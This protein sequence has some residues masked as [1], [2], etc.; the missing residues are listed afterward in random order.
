MKHTNVVEA[1]E[2]NNLKAEGQIGEEDGLYKTTLFF[3]RL[4]YLHQSK[5]LI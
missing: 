3:P 5:I 4:E 1:F 2:I